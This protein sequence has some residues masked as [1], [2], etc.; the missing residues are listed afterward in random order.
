MAV[1][2]DDVDACLLLVDLPVAGG[3]AG[4]GVTLGGMEAVGDPRQPKGVL[5]GC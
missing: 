2:S 5:K 1:D 4:V 3:R